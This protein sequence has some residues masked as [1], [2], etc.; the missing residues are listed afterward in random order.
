L[1]KVDDISL[2][3]IYDKNYELLKEKFP[4]KEILQISAKENINLESV[5]QTIRRFTLKGDL[6]KN[7]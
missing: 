7:L 2:K 4:D 5:V 6:N 3:E 1:N